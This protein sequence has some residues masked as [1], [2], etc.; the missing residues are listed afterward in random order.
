MNG[1]PIEALVI[2]RHLAGREIDM[3]SFNYRGFNARPPLEWKPV[4]I[5]FTTLAFA[6][7]SLVTA[8]GITLPPGAAS[9]VS[10]WMW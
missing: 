8:H 6:V 3:H 4:S 9:W 7:I 2:A 5:L 10:P 1:A